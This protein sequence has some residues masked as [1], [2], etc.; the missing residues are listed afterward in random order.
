MSWWRQLVDMTPPTLLF[1]L[2][3]HYTYISRIFP[4]RTPQGA[5]T[6]D[7]CSQSRHKKQKIPLTFTIS[8]IV[9]ISF[10]EIKSKNSSNCGDSIMTWCSSVSW[11]QIVSPYAV[12]VSKTG[13]CTCFMNPVKGL[14]VHL[15]CR[16]GK[17]ILTYLLVNYEPTSALK[18]K[19]WALKMRTH[20]KDRIVTTRL[21][22]PNQI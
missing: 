2:W 1:L 14:S 3:H 4:F 9:C 10:T 11:D 16:W 20:C 15:F 21:V 5:T 6:Q 7:W 18:Q 12:I 22:W 8:S 17:D 13:H 19:Q